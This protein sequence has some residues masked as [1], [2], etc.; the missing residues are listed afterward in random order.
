V[1]RIERDELAMETLGLTLAEGK[2]ILKAL[3]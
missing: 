1:A 3:T 2:L